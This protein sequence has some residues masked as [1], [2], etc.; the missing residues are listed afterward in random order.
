M[1]ILSPQ[2]TG[3]KVTYV[4]RSA[5]VQTVSLQFLFRGLRVFGVFRIADLYRTC[6][7]FRW[8]RGLV[9]LV[10]VDFTGFSP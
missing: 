4:K 6:A 8:R 2:P 7:S 9:T 5:W 1:K 10:I 3:G